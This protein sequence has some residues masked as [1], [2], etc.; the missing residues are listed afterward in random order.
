[1]VTV[2]PRPAQDLAMCLAA[3][4]ALAAVPARLAAETQ[5]DQVAPPEFRYEVRYDVVLRA[6]DDRADVTVTLGEGAYN[7][8]GIYGLLG[9]LE[10]IHEVGQPALQRSL[11]AEQDRTRHFGC[12][13]NRFF[14]RFA[15]AQGGCQSA[16]KGISSRNRVNRIHSK[17][18]IIYCLVTD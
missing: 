10:L 9:S 1:M 12:P 17:R 18:L 2:S 14:D 7:V 11:P 5:P 6:G 13:A 15:F 8:A 3:L 4:A 16:V